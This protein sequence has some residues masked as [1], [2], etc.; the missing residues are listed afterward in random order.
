MRKI[1]RP[2]KRYTTTRIKSRMFLPNISNN[3]V[4]EEDL[5][6]RSFIFNVYMLITKNLNPFSLKRYIF[7]VDNRNLVRIFREECIDQEFFK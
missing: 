1:M 3:D 5:H 7:D 4:K 2:D 6:D